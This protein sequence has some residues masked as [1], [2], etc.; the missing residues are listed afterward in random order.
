[1]KDGASP[2]F[3]SSPLR[4]VLI[5]PFVTLISTTVG[6]V[7]FLSFQNGQAAVNQVALE[8]RNQISDRLVQH[9]HSY[10]DAPNLVNQVNA[11]SIRQF[12][13]KNIETFLWRQLQ[14]F[15]S[16]N[17]I[18]YGTEKGEQFSARRDR[19]N[20]FSVAVQNIETKWEYR[21]YL[22]DLTGTPYKFISATAFDPRQRPW[23]KAA[24][25]S[26][27]PS[28]S[29]IY[30]D[31]V[32]QKLAIT[33]IQPFY[34]SQGKLQ[35]VLGSDLL[36]DE[37]QDFLVNLKV[38]K[39][40]KIFILERS[41]D[42]VS[43]ST[44]DRILA[45][46]L[47]NLPAQ[48]KNQRIK[49]I[50]SDNPI[51]RATSAYL[52]QKFGSW[53]RVYGAE[54]SSFDLN[55]N[56]QFLQVI[57]FSDRQSI[58]W[59]IVVVVPEA[60]FMEQIKLN[61]LITAIFCLIA[62]A[63]S[64]AISILIVRWITKPILR[65]NHGA[66]EL[67]RGRWVEIERSDR[68]DELGELTNYFRQMAEK[69]KESFSTLQQKNQLMEKLNEALSESGLRLSQFLAIIPVGIL[70]CDPK[71]KIYYTNPT[72][73]SM[74]GDRLQ[75][76]FP[77]DLE[78]L[79]DQLPIFIADRE[80]AYPLEKLP[81]SVAL[82][83]QSAVIED[84]EIRLETQIA[85]FQVWGNPIFDSE[86]NIVYA[87]AAFSDITSRCQA[88]KVMEEYSQ[89]LEK[90]VS[91]RT[92][93]LSQAMTT[94]ENTQAELIQREK[95]AVL[96]QLIAGVAHEINTPLGAIASAAQNMNDFLQNQLSEI[97]KFSVELKE[98][99]PEY[100]DNLVTLIQIALMPKPPLSTREQRQIRKE[101]SKVLS[102]HQIENPEAIA[103]QIVGIGLDRTGSETSLDRQ[104]AE[105]LPLLQMP[106]QIIPKV[107]QL[108]NLKTSTSTMAIAAERCAKI[109]FALKTY[110]H[111]QEQDVLT[112]TQIPSTIE[113]VLTL[114][115][116]QIKQ[117]VEVLRDYDSKLPAMLCYADDLTQVWTN[118]IHNA[119]QAMQNRGVLGIKT[120][121]KELGNLNKVAAIEISDSGTGIPLEL[122][123][124][125]FEPF[126][127]TKPA[128]EG[129]GL[130]LDIVRRIVEKHNGA[131]ALDSQPGSTTFTITLPIIL[132][133]K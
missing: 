45:N 8:L 132:P 15:P 102:L 119:L 108:A 48:T 57:P 44:R 94:L 63:A 83:G 103:N 18:Y 52:L 116:S 120:E 64:I 93:D 121:L 41:G 100:F 38:G 51:V 62:L 122:Q 60:D 123:A 127:T 111:Y 101:I 28:W 9:L 95:M 109:V 76:D 50:E 75:Q 31:L 97:L 30:T 33:A 99:K 34:N 17:T 130:G 98:T 35:G 85:R 88:Q 80:E 25:G 23:Y 81:I 7:G 131:I 22:V 133:D 112:L 128:G 12:K 72:I 54:S 89:T 43:I 13:T 126:F 1:V 114:Y 71:G 79:F 82:T 67:I 77:K 55:G 113:T 74:F 2:K 39:T 10:L 104:I 110:S 106:E 90:Q 26:G 68:A 70:V 40:G 118:L 19:A 115:Q 69:M 107:Y 21:R 84:L 37:L 32:S 105:F 129:S 53:E 86:E 124:K 46:N 20:A 92:Q 56:K 42:L 73:Q 3:L 61:T 96:G 11:N 14:L 49:A 47:A 59:L 87:I 78:R 4:L 91:E 24:S 65:L 66:K 29:T 5:V 16:L 27:Q 58:S 36:L 6:V 125:I 117:G